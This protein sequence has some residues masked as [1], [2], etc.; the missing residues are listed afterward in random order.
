MKAWPAS[1]DAG[2]THASTEK[3]PLNVP[4]GGR[5]STDWLTPLK[6]KARPTIPGANEAPF[7]RVPGWPPTTSPATASPG[8]HETALAGQAAHTAGGVLHFPAEPVR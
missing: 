4:S 3:T 5:T 1:W 8:H 7:S 2:F 6:L